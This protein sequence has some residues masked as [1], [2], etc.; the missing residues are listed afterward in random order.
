MKYADVELETF[1]DE[2]IFNATKQNEK[3]MKMYFRN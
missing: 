2:N 1:C 3:N